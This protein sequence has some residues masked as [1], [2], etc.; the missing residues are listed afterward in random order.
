MF[1][2]TGYRVLFPTFPTSNQLVARGFGKRRHLIKGVRLPHSEIS[3]SKCI[4]HSPKLIAAYHVLHRLLAPRHSLCA[5][6]S[7][8]PCLKSATRT[9]W[10][11]DRGSWIVDFFPAVSTLCR[12]RCR[13]TYRCCHRVFAVKNIVFGNQNI[14]KDRKNSSQDVTPA[15]RIAPLCNF[16]QSIK[17]YFSPYGC[18]RADWLLLCGTN[19]AFWKMVGLIGL[20]PMTPA[21]SR[22]CS[23]QLSYRP[24]WIVD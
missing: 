23:N 4:C 14:F 7:L 22:R 10:I 5:L 1:H 6:K 16:L 13:P 9:C 21:L 8:I 24:R 20:E 17:S 11:M 15:L 12:H 2:F 3:G 19:L 18:Q